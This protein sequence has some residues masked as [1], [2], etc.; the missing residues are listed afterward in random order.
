MKNGVILELNFDEKEATLN[1]ILFYC[2]H[3]DEKT[4]E[5]SRVGSYGSALRMKKERDL[6]YHVAFEISCS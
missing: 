6:L 4:K 5:L 2:A 3:C 1:A